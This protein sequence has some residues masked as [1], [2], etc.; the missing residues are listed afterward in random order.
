MKNKV[1]SILKSKIYVHEKN[2]SYFI[3]DIEQ[4]YDI[5]QSN[6]LNSD[7][8]NNVL[9]TSEKIGVDICLLVMCA[10]NTYLEDLKNHNNC[11]LSNLENNQLVIYEGKKYKYIKC[12]IINSGYYKGHEKIVLETKNGMIKIN[13]SEACKISRYFGESDKL[14]KMEKNKNDENSK[15]LISKLLHQD[16]EELSGI[17]NQQIIVVFKSRKYMEEILS[18][19]TIEVEREKYEFSRVFPS[20]YYSDYENYINIKGNKFHSKPIFLFTS[21]FDVADSLLEK[22][23]DC[24][25][26]IFLGE[27]AYHKS[28][29][30][31]ED[32]TLEEE[33]LNKIIFYNTYNNTYTINKLIENDV[34]VYA[35]E[36][37]NLK[38]NKVNNILADSIKINSLL[39]L[40]KKQLIKLL[41]LDIDFFQKEKFIKNTFKALKIYQLLC[42]PICEL[43]GRDI[44]NEC[45]NIAKKITENTFEYSS[46]YNELAYICANLKELYSELYNNNPKL[47]LLE[48]ISHKNSTIILNNSSELKF[49]QNNNKIKYKSAHILKNLRPVDLK[50]AKLIFTSFYDNKFINQFNLY[51]NN[52]T[53]NILYYTEAI[54]YNSLARNL[55]KSL[56][57]IYENNK[58]NH[59]FERKY[60]DLIKYKLNEIILKENEKNY[61]TNYNQVDYFKDDE[62]I[63]NDK[64]FKYEEIDSEYYYDFFD[65]TKDILDKKFDNNSIYYYDTYDYD[66]K[67]YKKIVFSNNQFA[68]LTKNYKACCIDIHGGYAVK[69]VDCL[70]INDKIIF[71]NDKSDEDIDLMFEKIINSNIFRKQY[72]KDFENVNYFKNIV[73][74]YAQKYENDY[75]LLSVE[76]S[77]HNI[78]KVPPAI[79][80]WTENKI[81]GPR[82]KEVYKV[83]GKITMDNKLLNE[84]ESIYNS[85]EVIR[86]FRSKFKS[87]FKHTLRSGMEESTD[88]EV[89]KLM[90]DIFDDLDDYVDIVE[91]EEIVDL[92]KVILDK[93]FNC[94]L[95]EKYILQGDK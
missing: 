36:E 60:V 54:K 58:I 17:L 88:N 77:H 38:K 32:Y 71:T 12:E 64:S 4:V 73:K 87:I 80:Q 10:I 35:L 13:K 24:N 7:Y 84:W 74:E 66:M 20:R 33:Q 41:N 62:N 59:K 90:I 57:L 83:M 93:Q 82:E 76:L 86:K 55:N 61:D 67:A 21:R 29:S 8:K 6:I 49:M 11:I 50:N 18:N 95:G 45:I 89:I 47:S 31:I 52:E 40:T 37:Q 30:I 39:Y 3:D 43:E 75:T 79:K 5:F 48:S 2:L 70:K 9:V 68:Y 22:N 51:N 65:K 19:L 46:I 78:E 28:L 56:F 94:L 26:L 42:I 81:I 92:D 23:E 15:N 53:T 27:Q 16:L 72:N 14:D 91:V 63:I 34:Q 1:L 85:S 25:K 69:N 44:L